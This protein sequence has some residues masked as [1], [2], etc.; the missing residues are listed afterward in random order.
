MVR[1]DQ[2]Q[3]VDFFENLDF[4]LFAKNY[5]RGFLTINVEWMDGAESP[6]LFRFFPF[7]HPI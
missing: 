2:G 5:L 6:S 1:L 3:S 7:S 4:V